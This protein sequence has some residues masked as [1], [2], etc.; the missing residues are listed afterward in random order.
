M[1]I[2]AEI[3]KKTW[4][5]KWEVE[6]WCKGVESFTHSV[7]PRKWWEMK[8]ESIPDFSIVVNKY[9]EV[10]KLYKG[11]VLESRKREEARKA[12]EKTS[13]RKNLSLLMIRRKIIIKLMRT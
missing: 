6:E 9:K 1:G 7:Y 11:V 10:C 4:E 13:R 12:A 8:E 2:E 5:F 3:R